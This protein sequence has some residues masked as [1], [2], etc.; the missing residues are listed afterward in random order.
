LWTVTTPLFSTNLSFLVKI[1]GKGLYRGIFYSTN[2]FAKETLPS[3]FFIFFEAM[4]DISHR[5][6]GGGPGVSIAEV[7]WDIT[8]DGAGRGGGP[9]AEEL[10]NLPAWD[11][12]DVFADSCDL[13]GMRGQKNRKIKLSMF[14]L[15]SI[16]G[17]VSLSDVRGSVFLWLSWIRIL[18]K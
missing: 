13:I 17:N 8:L 2:M 10:G 4:M 12:P 15:W 1:I 18:H 3:M 11:S 16:T 14:F 7:F 9:L 6:R 5:K